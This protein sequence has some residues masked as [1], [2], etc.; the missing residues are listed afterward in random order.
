M[1]CG[2]VGHR[3]A[4]V[5]PLL[6]LLLPMFKVLLE[7]MVARDGDVSGDVGSVC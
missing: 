5:L 6:L 7:R 3:E 1:R 2:L 4:A